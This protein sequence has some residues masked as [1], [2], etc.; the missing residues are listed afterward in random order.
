MSRYL[1]IIGDMVDSRAIEDRAAV[2]ARLNTELGR[3]NADPAGIA[4]P[5]TITLGD[6]FQAVLTAAPRAFR[7]AVALQAALH[8]VQVRFSL[9]LGP[10]VTAINPRQALGMDGPAFHAAR[11]GIDTLKQ[12]G[13]RYRISGLDPDVEALANAA[14]RLVAR[15]MDRWQ[16]RRFAI[17]RALQADTPVARIATDLGIS[18]QAVYKN[19]SSGHLHDVLGSFDAVGRLLTRALP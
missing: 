17:L 5:Y 14:L 12:D 2:Q 4:S 7:D 3:A 13:G 8:P 16:S 19:V 15:A 18:E 9:A 1:V 10:L 11:D 6:E